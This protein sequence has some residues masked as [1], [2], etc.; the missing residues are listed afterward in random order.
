MEHIAPVR[1]SMTLANEGRM[2]LVRVAM[3][4]SI[5]TVSV[6]HRYHF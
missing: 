1:I 4:V 5:E 6:G 2:S 3:L